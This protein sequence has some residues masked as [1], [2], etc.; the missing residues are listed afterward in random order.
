MITAIVLYDLPA[1]IDREACRQH[2][3]KIAPDFLGVPGFI[4][5][6]FIQEVDGSV[7]GGAYI[8]ENLA[9]AKAFYSGAWLA[10]IR[11]RYGCEPRITL[12]KRTR[13]PIRRP[14]MPAQRPGHCCP[15]PKQPGRQNNPGVN[16]VSASGV[17]QARHRPSTSQSVPRPA[18]GRSGLCRPDGR[19]RFR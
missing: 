2:F 5:K 17:T 15:R 8:W 14:V 6:Q 9:A 12:S 1:H 3:L 19:F 11:A 16:R 10:G 18:A 4:R 13:S 7:A